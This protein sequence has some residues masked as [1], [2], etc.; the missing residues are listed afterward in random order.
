MNIKAVILVILISVNSLFA[1]SET[2][3]TLRIKV[4]EIQLKGQ[5]IN[6]EIKELKY[7]IKKLEGRLRLAQI[8]YDNALKKIVEYQKSET[9]VPKHKLE[10]ENDNKEGAIKRRSKYGYEKRQKEA[11][12][13]KLEKEKA[14]LLLKYKEELT[15]LKN[16]LNT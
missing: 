15:K 12:L 13:V 4:K 2:P 8:D 11:S 7:Y 5:S 9:E 16:L 10:F 3:R 14:E 1:G 6:K